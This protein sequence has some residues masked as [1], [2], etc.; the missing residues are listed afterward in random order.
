M[1][2]S[3]K[4]L[5]VDDDEY[6]FDI[7]NSTLSDEFDLSYK[8]ESHG[9]GERLDKD[10]FDLILLDVDMPEMDGYEV[11]KA[12]RQR[13]N[14][15]Q[16]P[17]IFLSGCDSLDSRVKGY[18]VGGDDYVT[19]PY[20]AQEL[21]AKVR[22]LVNQYKSKNTF[23]EQRDRAKKDALMAI[24][25]T[26]ELSV[27][28][29]FLQK[30]FNCSSAQEL[31]S[32]IVTSC[33]EYSASVLVRLDVEEGYHFEGTTGPSSALEQS[34]FDHLPSDCRI[35]MIGK[36]CFFHYGGA[37]LLVKNMPTEDSELCGRLRDHFALLAEGA[38]SILEKISYSKAVEQK[39]NLKKLMGK[40]CNI[41]ELI[42][43]KSSEQRLATTQIMSELIEKIEH[44][45]FQLGLTEE[46]EE[47]L[48]TTIR[49]AEA[50]QTSIY[51]LGDAIEKQLVSLVYGFEKTIEKS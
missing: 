4:I 14:T 10:N 51:E 8:E 18:E 15:P 9:I 38:G 24:H 30:S 5:V 17:V 41:L 36:R 34:I 46:Q 11:C 1:A 47:K 40:A 32:A 23:R 7:L 6:T 37:F 43:N 25:N 12:I 29:Q 19:K 48:L 28:I 49:E 3:A 31:A 45:F 20:E 44:E 33:N 26:G 13:E 2:T 21:R 16:I 39:E 22:T 27:V 50:K 42:E 35:K